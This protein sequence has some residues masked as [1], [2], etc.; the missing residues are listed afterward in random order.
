MLKETNNDEGND[1]EGNDDKGNKMKDFSDTAH[2]RP[3]RFVSQ[4]TLQDYQVMAEHVSTAAP[5]TLH[6]ALWPQ[7]VRVA[8][9]LR[10]MAEKPEQEAHR[11]AYH[12]LRLLVW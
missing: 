8:Q 9:S 5:D 3:E 2:S 1:D 10:Q 7:R 12:A 11:A 4:P 6:S